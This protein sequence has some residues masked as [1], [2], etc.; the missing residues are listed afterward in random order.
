MGS[1]EEFMAKLKN[2]KEIEGA[3][4]RFENGDMYKIKTGANLIKLG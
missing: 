2:E 3:V 1:L 4:I